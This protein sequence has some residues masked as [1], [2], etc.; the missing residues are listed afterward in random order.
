MAQRPHAA[1]S[2]RSSTQQVLNR[3]ADKCFEQVDPSNPDELNGFITFME[4][5]R[6]VLVLDVE[7]GSLI[8]KLECRSVKILDDL[9]QDYRTGHLNEVAQSYLVTNDI[10]KEF[11]LSSFK[12]TSNIKEEDYRACRQRLIIDGRFEKIIIYHLQPFETKL[13]KI[14]RNEVVSGRSF[15]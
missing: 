15:H 12:L 9:W 8:F 10:L 14:P 6:N 7:T 13:R 2:T 4:K 5:V 1:S 11:G 3:I